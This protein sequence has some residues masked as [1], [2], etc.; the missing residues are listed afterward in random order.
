[1]TERDHY[2][3]RAD[4]PR[5]GQM[6]QPSERR[7]GELQFE[8]RQMRPAYSNRERAPCDHDHGHQRRDLH[9]SHRLGAGVLDTENI[10]MPEINGHRD[11][12][13]GGGEIWRQNNSAVR[14]L[15]QLV[16]Q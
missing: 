4:G 13:E 1:M 6:S 8:R 11:R 7:V 14:E 9:D 2:S 10:L 15:E 5:A 3:Y 12:E 16:D